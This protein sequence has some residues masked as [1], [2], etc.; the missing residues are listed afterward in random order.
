MLPDGWT[1]RQAA[2]SRAREALADWDAHG[3]MS[4]RLA[5]ML[6]ERLRVLLAELDRERDHAET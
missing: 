3:T 4:P 1:A 2:E 5:M 6:A